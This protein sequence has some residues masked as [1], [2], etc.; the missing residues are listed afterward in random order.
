MNGCVVMTS[1][2]QKKYSQ[3]LDVIE[4]RLSL[5]EFSVLSGRSYRQCQ[6]AIAAVKKDGMRGIHHGNSGRVPKNKSCAILKQD[7]VR[8]MKEK[9][10]DFNLTH[11]AEKL[12]LCE[13]IRVKRETLRTWAHEVGTPKKTRRRSSNKI[14]QLRPRM[15]RMGMLIQFDG[16]DHDWFS[17]NG[18]RAVLV[19]GIDDATGEVL[20]IEF[21][22]AEDTFSCLKVIRQITEKYGIAEAYYFDQAGHFGKRNTEQDATQIG[23]ALG[24]LGMK[25]LLAS[26]PQAKGRVE[27]LWGTMQDRLVAEL[28]LHGINRMPAANEF[29]KNEF[30]P[31]YNAQ[32]AVSPRSAE[33]AFKPVPQYKDLRNIFC[34]KET[35]KISGAHQFSYG[36]ET[37]LVERTQ[38]YRFRTVQ[39][40]SYEDGKKEFEIHGKKVQVSKINR[41]QTEIVKVAA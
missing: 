17:G 4:G 19:G 12:L 29:I 2:D 1:K 28:R 7:V 39:I 5:T 41:D 21:F 9:Y 8:L 23:R 6:R 32:F 34:V 37:Y 11:L 35:R 18:P 16:S 25:A 30:L 27:R 31:A 40:L 3:V 38:D 26:T 13:G 20:W 10:F 14:H 22:P 33:T 24:E 15:P 36:N